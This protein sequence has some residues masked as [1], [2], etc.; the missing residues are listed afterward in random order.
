MFRTRDEGGRGG[1][2]KSWAGANAG[3]G[4]EGGKDG[5][6]GGLNHQLIRESMAIKI[7]LISILF[8]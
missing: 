1:E 4:R 2:A 5:R 3:D 6:L 7:W 8:V